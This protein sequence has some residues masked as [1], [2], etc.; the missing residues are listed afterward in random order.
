MP[1]LLERKYAAE[2]PAIPAPRTITLFPLLEDSCVDVNVL[3]NKIIR[4]SETSQ[5]MFITI[6]TL[7]SY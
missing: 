4:F 3:V 2:T 5:Q 6:W 7:W 1:N